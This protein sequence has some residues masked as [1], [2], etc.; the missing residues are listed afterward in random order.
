LFAI[1]AGSLFNNVRISGLSNALNKRIDDLRDFI[2]SGN[3]R[4][5]QKIDRI[6]DTLTAMKA[7]HPHP[8]T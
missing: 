1:A 5:E 7:A 2:H 6:T 8:V 4:K 3:L